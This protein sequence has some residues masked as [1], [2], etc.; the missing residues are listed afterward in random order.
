MSDVETWTES[1]YCSSSPS[2]SLSPVI[3]PST[4]SSFTSSAVVVAV[5]VSLSST[6][7]WEPRLDLSIDFQFDKK[8]RCCMNA[9]CR[10]NQVMVGMFQPALTS[11]LLTTN[12]SFPGPAKT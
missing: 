1:Q 10:G 7:S 11:P 8:T 12:Q 3:K 2:V 9:G 5:S 4:F 6:F